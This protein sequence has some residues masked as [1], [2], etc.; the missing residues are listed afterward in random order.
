MADTKE[1]NDEYQMP[2]LD[3]YSE[4]KYDQPS[5]EAASSKNSVG[6]L[7]S[8]PVL[9]KAGLVVIAVVLAMIA[10]KFLGS[11]FSGSGK[12]S[13]SS[14]PMLSQKKDGT[15]PKIAS[16]P[17]KATETPAPSQRIST[18]ATVNTP[19]ISKKVASLEISQQTLRDTMSSIT[20]Q[21]GTVNGTVSGLSDQI[22]SINQKL[23][24]LMDKLEAQSSQIQRLKSNTLAKKKPRRKVVSTPA[25]TWNV[26]AVVPGRA[27]LIASNGST[28]TVRNGSVIPN[29]GTVSMIDTEQGRV[30]LR[31]GRVI[32][33]SSQDS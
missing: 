15:L 29:M 14:M 3:G 4:E 6:T 33:F 26:Q 27:W 1:P 7:R 22:S 11:M 21:V 2:D 9:Q 16:I 12:N 13:K 5:Y 24:S 28:L 25:V 30:I 17:T 8:N 23:E 19:E 32:T 10:Y 31:S 18:S 20:D